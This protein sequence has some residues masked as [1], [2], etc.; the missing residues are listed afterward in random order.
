MLR[1]DHIDLAVRDVDRSLLFYL[2]VLGPLGLRE[3]RRVAS[4]RGTEEIVYLAL[5]GGDQ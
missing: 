3:W 4:Y 2:A 1:I 5:P